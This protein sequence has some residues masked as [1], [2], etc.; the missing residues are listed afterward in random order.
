MQVAEKI[1]ST[2]VN[3]RFVKPL[4]VEIIKEMM[5]LHEVIV[6]VEENVIMGGAGSACNEVIIAEQ[7]G[8]G[9]PKHKF[10]RVL[11]IGLPDRYIDHGTPKELLIEEGL[12]A[13][14]IFKKVESLIKKLNN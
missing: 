14:G 11:N 12:S 6:T 8:I 1:D 4:D 5:S 13:D 10:S 2:V 7:S 9:A 3:M